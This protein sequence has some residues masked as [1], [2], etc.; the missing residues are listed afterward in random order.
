[1]L[2]ESLRD[3]IPDYAKDIRLNLS[4]VLT[5]EGSPGLSEAQIAGVALASA[6]ASRNAELSKA[7]RT[8]VSSALSESGVQAAKMA[9]ALMGMTNVYYRF[10]HLVGD[11]DYKTMASRLRTNAMADP[12]VDRVDFEFYCLAV[13]AVNGCGG[14][15]QAHARKL[16]ESGLTKEAVQSAVR[17][18]AVIQATA[19]VFSIEAA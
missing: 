15:V 18:A 3:R 1:M 2:T 10:V 9:S 14:C 6:Y 11:P 7:V 17:I 4:S 5:P 12:G 19:Q 16:V 13:S 8:E